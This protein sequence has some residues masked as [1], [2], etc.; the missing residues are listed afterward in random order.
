MLGQL[1]HCVVLKGRLEVNLSH[2]HLGEAVMSA[3]KYM[4]SQ[5]DKLLVSTPLTLCPE[6]S[7]GTLVGVDISNTELMRP[8]DTLAWAA[9]ML[10]DSSP[11]P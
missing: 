2:M 9:S 3:N 4:N 1:G 11:N 10:E 5:S 7:A 6:L 8:S